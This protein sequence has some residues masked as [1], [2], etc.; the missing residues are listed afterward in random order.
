[1]ARTDVVQGLTASFHTYLLLLWRREEQRL[2]VWLPVWLLGF[3]PVAEQGASCSSIS[4]RVP[5]VVE[6]SFATFSWKKRRNLVEEVYFLS[7]RQKMVCVMFNP[8]SLEAPTQRS[9]PSAPSDRAA[10]GNARSTMSDSSQCAKA[11]SLSGRMVVITLYFVAVTVFILPT[12]TLLGDKEL[13][14]VIL[15]GE[16]EPQHDEATQG[17]SGRA[18]QLS[19]PPLLPY[20]LC[21]I[22]VPR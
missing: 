8:P 20:Q 11:D 19:D 6:V 1:M 16:T 13:L 14:L 9:V 10:A 2:P 15:W 21:L 18:A 3:F 7:P 5:K 17:D 4:P 22:G 12:P